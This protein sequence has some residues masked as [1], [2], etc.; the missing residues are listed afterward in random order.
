MHFVGNLKEELTSSKIFLTNLRC[1]TL[2]DF[3][4][5]KDMFLTYVL[6]RPDST[7]PFWKKKFITGL[8]NLFSQRIMSNLQKEMGV[9]QIDFNFM[10]YDQLFAFIKKEALA[11]C[12]ELKFQAKY[13]NKRQEMGSFCEAFGI[14]GI[15]A[16]STEK[17]RRMITSNK[18][19]PR[20][21]R[22]SREEYYKS[23]KN[24]NKRSHKNITCYKC[25][26]TGHMANKCKS[27]IERKGKINETID[28]IS[29]IDNKVKEKLKKI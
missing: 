6:K 5:Y 22:Q 23:N 24:K 15:R 27:K 17:K 4:W 20:K 8:P 11:A 3:R 19:K 29:D 21:P 14:T 9:E 18:Y 7:A 28:Q 13:G 16:P 2:T 12:Q 1:P 25:E 26:K 10:T